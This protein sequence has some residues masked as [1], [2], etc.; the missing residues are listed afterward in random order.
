MNLDT[1]EITLGMRA[2]EPEQIVTVAEPYFETL[3]RLPAENTAEV[4]GHGRC[5]SACSICARRPADIDAE[6]RPKLLERL[7]LGRCDTTGAQH[8]AS[9][10]ALR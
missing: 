6:P 3:R 5:V 1:Y 9:D 10:T 7:V 8:E 2:R 4:E